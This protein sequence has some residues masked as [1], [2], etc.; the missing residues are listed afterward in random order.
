M[1]TKTFVSHVICNDGMTEELRGYSDI[2]IETSV[3]LWIW[4]TSVVIIPMHRIKE[5]VA[6]EE[7]S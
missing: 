6:T 1:T 5:I 3:I 4:P 2:K 7:E